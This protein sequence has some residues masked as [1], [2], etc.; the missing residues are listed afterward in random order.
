MQ[1]Q[2]HANQRST[3]VTKTISH[4]D[5]NSK[6]MMKSRSVQIIILLSKF[7]KLLNQNL[8]NIGKNP[9][10]ENLFLNLND[11]LNSWKGDKRSDDMQSD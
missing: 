6:D 11:L 5:I 8:P 3:D 7:R 1:R 2:F 4:T 9:E 10:F